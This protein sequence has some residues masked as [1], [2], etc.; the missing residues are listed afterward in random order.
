M[1]CRAR[2]GEPSTSR[3]A[4]RT[5]TH[6]P[7]RSPCP[8]RCWPSIR[9]SAARDPVLLALDDAQ[10]LDA[11]SARV[12]E[13]VVR[14]LEHEPVALVATVRSTDPRAADPPVLRAVPHERLEHRSVGPLSVDALARL[15]GERLGHVPPRTLAVRIRELSGGN[16]FYAL[17]LGRAALAQGTQSLEGDTRRPG[18][19]ERTDAR[20][21]SAACPMARGTRSPSRG[22]R[23][24]RPGRSWS[25]PGR[26]GP[27]TGAGSARDADIAGAALDTAIAAGIVEERA[28]GRLAFT[29]PLLAWAAASTPTAERREAIHER[30]AVVA[31]D[32]DE[33]VRHLAI[34]HTVRQRGGRRGPA[35]GGASGA[36]PG[37][38]GD[39]DRPRARCRPA[40]PC[41]ASKT[42]S[43]SGR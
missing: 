31:P 3:C 4:G 6:R 27:G 29:H 34:V 16:P 23:S 18:V 36:R 30:L 25:R 19:P 37:R 21:E 43:T 8:R 11:P 9:R 26:D 22:S 39:G 42:G 41:R 2:N 15:L 20:T 35:R 32:P 10:W 7:T 40:H 28:D 17:E 14:R 24:S 1:R 13:F 12:L 38:A 5:T 33:R